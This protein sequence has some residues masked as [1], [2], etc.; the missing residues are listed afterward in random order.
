[1]SRVPAS[2][3]VFHRFPA[4]VDLCAMF[5]LQVDIVWGLDRGMS[6]LKVGWC[7]VSPV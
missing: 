3:F 5:G 6:G 2:D 7:A 1:M 4:E